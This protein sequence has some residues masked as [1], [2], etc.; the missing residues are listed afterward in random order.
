MCEL[1]PSTIQKHF[2]TLTDIRTANKRHLLIDIITISI[3]AVICGASTYEQIVAFGKAKFKWLDTF[4][5][6]PNGIPSHDTF[7]RVFSIIDP[8]EFQ[9]SFMEWV[10]DVSQRLEKEI[11]AI[12]GKTLRRSHDNASG[13][14]AIHMVNAWATGSNI[15]LGQYKTEEKSNEITAIPLLLKML[16]ISDS[17]I[18]IDAMGCQKKIASVIIDKKADY[19]LSLKENHPMMYENTKLYL[20]DKIESGILGVDYCYHETLDGEH[21]RIETRKYWITSDINFLQGKENW[22]KLNSIGVV[23]RT[24][25][26]GEKISV[27]KHYYLT[28]IESDAELFA[29]AV[30]NHWG[31]ENGLHWTLDMAFR[32][33]ECRIRKGYAPEN[34]SVLRQMA[35][36]LLKSEKSFK[37]SINTKRLEAAW[38]K[39]YL[40]TVINYK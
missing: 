1:K 11:I 23:E 13:K 21:G 12:D 15:V 40:K 19:V 5:E 35:L 39:D 2:G 37:G 16:D 24:R 29:K 6:L 20:D 14:K 8:R 18:T 28:S 38:N 25:E 9:N 3:C 4:L 33:D 17:I 36:N 31:V 7:G 22:K 34:F 32:E 10:E 27:E 26:I 30:R